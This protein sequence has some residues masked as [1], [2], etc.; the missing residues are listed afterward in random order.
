[1]GESSLSKRPQPAATSRQADITIAFAD[2]RKTV[3]KIT[4][5]A[6]WMPEDNGT[7]E[8]TTCVTRSWALPLDKPV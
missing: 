7:R 4:R 2:T 1:M 5:C 6:M 8:W 3:M